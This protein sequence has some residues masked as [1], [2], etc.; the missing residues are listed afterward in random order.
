MVKDS[1]FTK[2]K[3]VIDEDLTIRNGDSNFFAF[4]GENA[5]YSLARSVHPD[6]IQRIEDAVSELAKERVNVIALRMVGCDGQYRWMLVT[7]KKDKEHLISMECQDVSEYESMIDSLKGNNDTITEYFSL[8]EYLMISYDIDTDELKI[9][10]LGSH[11]QIN[12]YNGT[13]SEWCENK[14]N[15][16]DVDEKSMEAFNLLCDD[17]RNGTMSFKRELKMNF[18]DNREKKKWCLIKGKTANNMSRKHQVIATMSVINPV[19]G[20]GSKGIPYI[21]EIK[22]AG[23]DLLNKR[24]ITNYARKLIESEPDY[25]VTIAIIDIDDF[26]L[27]NDGYGHMVGDEVINNVA[28]IIKNAVEGKGISGRIGGDE[29]F[30]V[31]ENLCTKEEIRSVL[32]TIRNN[33]EWMY[34]NDD[35]KPAVTCSI[36][37]A[38]YP[39]DA[40]DYQS[41]FKL[42]DKMLY[43]A[44]EKGR[45]RYIIYQENFHR[46]Y[47]NGKGKA[48][49]T[50]EF[51]Y[52]YRK[53]VVINDIVNDYCIQHIVSSQRV[54]E[55]IALTFGLGS[56]CIYDINGGHYNKYVLYG[57]DNN[58]IYDGEYMYHDNYFACFREDNLMIIDNVNFYERKAPMLYRALIDMDINQSIHVDVKQDV[59]RHRI[60]T[61]NRKL[62]RRQWG[63]SDIIYL[64][65]LGNILGKRYSYDEENS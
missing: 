55:K 20:N 17:F 30:I 7:L 45:N 56:I 19:N 35:S 38:T 16:G 62:N 41:L 65:I 32:R 14:I 58:S 26:K 33:V 43:L 12:F 42:A 36:G 15:N 9:F 34:A 8:M 28:D 37:S 49:D 5:I 23:T 18:F 61:F 22:D 21:Q 3:A 24:A 52:K 27:V 50:E 6:D 44:K 40:K 25:P 1:K 63:E 51:F 11:E 46:D 54:A 39:L 31:M 48:R 59:C 57:K 29:M 10:M 4:I 47:V 13:L 60:V 64:S 2:C 53:N